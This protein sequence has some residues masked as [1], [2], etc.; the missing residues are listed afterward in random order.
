MTLK[1][2]VFVGAWLGMVSVL[3][4]DVRL[5]QPRYLKRETARASFEASMRASRVFAEPTD[6]DLE[7]VPCGQVI[8]KS[9]AR[10]FPAEDVV[11]LAAELDWALQDGVYGDD[12]I[13]L[14]TIERVLTQLGKTG[15]GLRLQFQELRKTALPPEDPLW[16]D[17]YRKACELRRNARLSASR[18]KLARFVFTKHYD[19]GGSHYAYTEGLS[20]AANERHFRPGTSLCILEM[21]GNWGKVKTLI[22]DRK[23]VIRDPD[24]SWDGKRILF[25]WK[26]SDREDDYHLYEMTP[27]DGQ[28]RQIT[29]GLG[30]A[31]YEGQYLP[32]GD[33][34]FSS[35]RCVQAVDCWWT[36][37]SNLYT[38]AP[39]GKYLRRLGFDQVHTNF[40]T[41]LSDGRVIYTRWE[42][43]DRGQIYVQSLFQ[44]H[45]DGTGQTEFYGNNSW[46]P[47]SIL[48]ARGLPGSDKVVA[49]LSGH[50]TIQKGWLAIVD[51]SKGRQENSGTQLIAPVRHTPAD[52]IDAYGQDG[53]QFQYPYPLCDRE[54]LVTFKPEG[55]QSRFGVF[56]MNLAGERELLVVDPAV[57]CNQPIPLCP[58]PVPPVRPNAVDYRKT[59]GLVYMQ[60]IY[61]GPGLTGV[62]RG[63]VKNL[64][65]VAI[66]YRAAA[67]N[68]N[69]NSGPAGGAMVSTPIS[70]EGA[71]D[72][73]VVLGTTKVH[74]DG[75]A[76]FVAPAKTPFYFQALDENNQA[77]QTMRSWMT[78]QPGETASC[79][80]CHENKNTTP[81]S[82][83]PLTAAMRA[84]PQTLVEP[85]GGA[86]GF[87]FRKEIQPILDR[88]CVSCH[89]VHDPTR[90]V[91][92]KGTMPEE[93]TDWPENLVENEP[94]VVPP[95]IKPAFSL[96]GKGQFWSPAYRSLANRKLT[97]WI[98]AQ[99]EPN[100]LPPYHAGST[101]SK[102]IRVLRDGHY[103]VN[104]T[105]DE[106]DAFSC[107]IDLLVPYL[108]SYTECMNSDDLAKYNRMI[109]KRRNWEQQEQRNISDL[110]RERGR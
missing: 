100:M 68:S 98:N 99:S 82:S 110:I 6:K 52:R 41:V 46:F 58:R 23:G 94:A 108:G 70:I 54:F 71:W 18:Q 89:F 8:L 51:P 4:A 66:E 31:D 93:A 88:K 49:I 25:S 65:V 97:N 12:G 33:L 37:V 91:N 19:L 21:I 92:P 14:N 81:L 35:T 5:Y 27:A 109:A 40:P 10:D 9:L 50:H 15:E 59:T 30:F 62:P 20:D 101:R 69:S 36:E 61:A 103:D 22:D 85:A 28:I 80:G 77:I 79:V 107:W 11:R 3:G 72:V 60:D 57:S 32:N 26:K 55:S 53:D 76:C 83:G 42:Y 73:K 63:A 29:S 16:M 95:E 90:L 43:S 84:G 67:I 38:C 34:V 47:T 104:L 1:V 45:P 56:W 106:M 7:F 64:R 78:L 2:R 75:S 44:M 48:H 87:S 96:R 39:D 17:L 13:R 24:V 105:R 102:L 86:R 74:D